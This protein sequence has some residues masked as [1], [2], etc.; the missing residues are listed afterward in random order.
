MTETLPK[1]KRAATVTRRYGG[2]DAAERRRE[3]QR[4]LVDAGMEM[5]GKKGYHLSTVR[6]LC[7]EAGLT[8]RYFYESFSTLGECFDAVYADLRTQLQQR[9]MAAVLKQG[10]VNQAPMDMGQSTLRAWY[11]FMHEDPRR[12]R[13]MLIDAVSVSDTGMRGA[14]SA[15]LEFSGMLKTFIT[16]MYPDLANSGFDLNVIAAAL[17]GASIYIAKDWIRSGFKMSVDEV[18]RHNMALFHSLDAFYRNAVGQPK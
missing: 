16:M 12:A 4:K 13:I 14:E 3:R 17:S 9:I 15:V 2:M 7:T 10:M 6:D 18:L 1:K 8:E 11:V 5:F